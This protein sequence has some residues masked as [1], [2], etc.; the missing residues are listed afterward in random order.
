MTSPVSA[1][2][3][4]D[5]RQFVRCVL[6]SQDEEESLKEEAAHRSYCFA[7]VDLANIHTREDLMDRLARAL[8]FPSYF[9][10]NWDAFLDMVTD[11]SWNPASGYI[12]LLKN[13][14]SLLQLPSEHLAT[15]V[16]LCSAAVERWQSGEDEEGKSVP[17]TPFYFLL[18]G[19]PSFCRL[20][21]DL[22]TGG[23]SA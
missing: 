18:E 2:T 1:Q 12:V 10:K 13:A 9:G 14:E 16:R 7:V 22:L 19:Q 8:G 11:L 5:D 6:L 4:L 20:V 15:F 21:T 3:L 17:R 23:Q